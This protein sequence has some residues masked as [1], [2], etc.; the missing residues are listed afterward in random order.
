MKPYWTK[1]ETEALSLYQ[2][3]DIE[4]RNRIFEETL[5]PA[6]EKMTEC[7]VNM[8]SKYNSVDLNQLSKDTIAH[9][10]SYLDKL[11]TAK[12]P[13][14]YLTMCCKHF[15]YQYCKKQHKLDTRDISL[16]VI[17]K[18]N[19]DCLDLIH[20]QMEVSFDNSPIVEENF[21]E[22]L[23][24]TLDYWTIPKLRTY[25]GTLP[26]STHR[27]NHILNS[28]KYSLYKLGSPHIKFEQLNG[29]FRKQKN[30]NLSTAGYYLTFLAKESKRALLK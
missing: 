24:A 23:R 13:F 18:D 8:S 25:L 12:N 5:L 20:S 14:G 4:E 21:D 17:D 15:V 1:I 19:E 2:K 27:R 28:V 26:M 10:V 30:F 7:V 16:N 22:L 3:A 6:L 29:N 11:D 9:M